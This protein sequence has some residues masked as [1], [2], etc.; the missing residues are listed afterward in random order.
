MEKIGLVLN[1]KVFLK[2]YNVLWQVSRIKK[3]YLC[4]FSSNEVL[5][6]KKVTSLILS[7]C[8]SLFPFK[9]LEQCIC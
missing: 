7:I 5:R 1:E 2:N 6:G 9:G 4:L 3:F 8:D